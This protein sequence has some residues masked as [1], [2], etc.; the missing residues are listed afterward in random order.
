M[1]LFVWSSTSRLPG[2]SER[3]GSKSS[4]MSV[5]S[6]WFASVSGD[7]CNGD[8]GARAL[9]ALGAVARPP[10][11]VPI[12]HRSPPLWEP[13]RCF[14]NRSVEQRPGVDVGSAASVVDDAETV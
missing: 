5:R 12:D 14:E 9:T 2:F 6:I 13:R 8:D 7:F 1:V 3:M 10:V 4:S 11:R